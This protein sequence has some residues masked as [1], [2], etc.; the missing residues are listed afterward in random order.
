M[1][2]VEPF[3][4]HHLLVME[5]RSEQARELALGDQPLPEVA[6]FYANAGPCFTIMSRLGLPGYEWWE[7]IMCGGVIVRSPHSAS[8]WGVFSDRA[9]GH[10]LYVYH[11]VR[12]FIRTQEHKRLDAW[13]AQDNDL[14]LR[15]VAALG[16]EREGVMGDF[17]APGVDAL[18]YRRVY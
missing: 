10:G 5:A 16:F 6:T 18:V 3:R 7:P 8:L 13:V 1:L 17:F 15:L 4:P 11:R 12:N 9:R 14:A 2:H